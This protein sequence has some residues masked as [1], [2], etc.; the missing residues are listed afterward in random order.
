MNQPQDLLDQMRKAVEDAETNLYEAVAEAC[1]GTLH[2]TVQHRD[3][4]PPWCPYCGRTNRGEL[5][6]GG[7]PTT[8]A[9]IPG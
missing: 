7:P 5:V 8:T 9:S 2:R 6:G 1:P 4:K 3:T